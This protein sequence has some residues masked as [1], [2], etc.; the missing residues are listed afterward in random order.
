[1]RARVITRAP[2]AVL[3]AGIGIFALQCGAA[4]EKWLGFDAYSGARGLCNEHVLGSSGSKRVEIH[5]QSFAS[6]DATADVIDFYARREGKNVQRS[7]DSLEVRHGEDYVLT[8]QPASKGGG[9]SCSTKPNTDEK[10]LII[11]S[12]RH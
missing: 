7:A 10:T 4:P 6:R 9:P 11:V 12:E 3:A 5:W 8:V 2:R 1:M